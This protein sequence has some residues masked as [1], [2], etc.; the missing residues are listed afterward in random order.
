MAIVKATWA[1]YSSVLSLNLKNADNWMENSSFAKCQKIG[2][3]NL[4][5]K[6]ILQSL[7]D[8]F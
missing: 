8:L 5:V 4:L 2:G 7:S 6:K 1:A 3:V